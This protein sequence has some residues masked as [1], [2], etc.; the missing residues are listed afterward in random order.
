MHRR[1]ALGGGLVLSTT[2]WMAPSVLTLDRVAAATASVAT[3][4]PVASGGATFIPPPATIR[5]GTTGLDSNTNTFV[6][7]EVGPITLTAGLAVNRVTAGSG[8][9]GNSNQNATIPAGTQICSF[10]AHGDRLDD[11]GSLTGTMTF[12]SASII[13]LIYRTAQLNSS[14]FLRAP[15]TTY[16]NGPMENSDSMWLDL[17]PGANSVRWNMRFG[18]ALD[19]IRVITNCCAP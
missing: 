15:G 13:G 18:P 16:F 14:S 3:D 5:E 7:Q 6:F 4:I 2:A 9:G 1:K 8:F 12:G 19:G 11:S 17:T 10:Y